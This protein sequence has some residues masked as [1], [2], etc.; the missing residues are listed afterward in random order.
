VSSSPWIAATAVPTHYAS[1]KCLIRACAAVG[2]AVGATSAGLV[3][4]WLRLISACV[5]S[6]SAMA[7]GRHAERRLLV[8]EVLQGCSTVLHSAAGDRVH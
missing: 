5:L 8:R 2:V 3:D 1:R 7:A 6:A 4:R